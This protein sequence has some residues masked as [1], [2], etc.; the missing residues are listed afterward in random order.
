MQCTSVVY[1]VCDTCSRLTRCTL[2]SPLLLPPAPDV[3][4]GALQADAAEARARRA[5][6]QALLRGGAQQHELPISEHVAKLP[7]PAAAGALGM[8]VPA[9]G[10]SSFSL[11]TAERAHPDSSRSGLAATCLSAHSMLEVGTP[12]SPQPTLIDLGPRRGSTA[13]SAA[14]AEGV[15]GPV[16]PRRAR[17]WF[18]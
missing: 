10:S 5:G 17:G 8:A 7:A 13:E 11:S 18:A 16:S 15:V 12:L 1:L 6:S 14:E 4:T 3:C 9:S 2:T